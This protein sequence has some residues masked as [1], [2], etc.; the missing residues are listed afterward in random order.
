M[1]RRCDGGTK[2]KVREVPWLFELR[3]DEVWV[4]RETT[5]NISTIDEVLRDSIGEIII[6][7]C[8]KFK[9]NSEYKEDRLTDN[10]SD[11]CLRDHIN[12]LLSEKFQNAG[13]VWGKTANPQQPEL[14]FRDLLKD[15]SESHLPNNLGGIDLII[16]PNQPLIKGLATQEFED[17]NLFYSGGNLYLTHI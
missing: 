4:Y 7:A 1:F 15:N 12:E 3:E 14:S 16:S 8:V 5:V 17:A 10:E 11:I 9:Q 6:C 13:I 2:R